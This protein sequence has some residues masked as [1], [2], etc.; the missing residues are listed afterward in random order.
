MHLLS[1]V[2]GGMIGA[3]VAGMALL[4]VNRNNAKAAVKS[5]ELEELDIATLIAAGASDNE[6]EPRFNVGDP[7]IIANPYVEVITS[8]D[9][10]KHAYVTTVAYDEINDIYAYQVA[11]EGVS[12]TE[13]YNENWLDYDIYGKETYKLIEMKNAEEEAEAEW[14]ANIDYWLRS[15]K[16]EKTRGNEAEAQRCIDELKELTR[17]E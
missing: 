17:K 1:A 13:W 16:Y 15:L 6:R 9:T 10:P 7:V 2:I 8:D 14:Q 5:E 4:T 12:S 3:G 11:G